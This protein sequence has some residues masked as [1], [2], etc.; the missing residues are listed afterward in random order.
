M[1]MFKFVCKISVQSANNMPWTLEGENTCTT[2]EQF[3]TLRALKLS[4]W[5][6]ARVL[7]QI[8]LS[9]EKGHLPRI[10]PSNDARQRGQAEDC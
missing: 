3:P 4:P 9:G 6:L 2:G 10:H 1:Q 8:L 5:M 7:P